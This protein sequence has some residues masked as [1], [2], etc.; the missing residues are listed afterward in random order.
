MFFLGFGVNPI[1]WTFLDGWFS[2]DAKSAVDGFA[3]IGYFVAVLAAL[4]VHACI[5]TLNA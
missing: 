1:P 2:C 3:N 5:E 4:Q